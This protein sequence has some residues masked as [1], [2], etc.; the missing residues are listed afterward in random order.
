MPT[1]NAANE[2]IKREYFAYLREAKRYA[3]VSLDGV[4]KAF[5]RF[6]TYTRHRDF[7]AF[8]IQQAIG[9]KRHLAEQENLRT[10]ERLSKATL[11]ST[12]VV[13]FPG[14]DIGQAPNAPD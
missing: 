6:E 11:Y 10:K 5:N 12:A 3:E 1:H 14:V 8:H 4:A 2:R 7:K 13:P 9:F